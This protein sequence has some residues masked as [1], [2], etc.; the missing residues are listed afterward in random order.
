MAVIPPLQI[1]MLDEQKRPESPHEEDTIKNSVN[2]D[3]GN[4]V[5]EMAEKRVSELRNNFTSSD[6]IVAAARQKKTKFLSLKRHAHALFASS[7]RSNC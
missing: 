1:A 7:V 5:G 6:S 4:S 3:S 2:R